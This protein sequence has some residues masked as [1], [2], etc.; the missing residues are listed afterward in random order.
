MMQQALRK[1]AVSGELADLFGERL[2][3]LGRPPQGDLRVTISWNTDATD[4]DLWV[5]EPDGVKCFY[6]NKWTKSGGELSEDMRQGYGPERYQAKKALTGEYRILVHYFA[7]NPNLLGGETH[8][9]VVV[10]RFAGTP[11]EETERYTVILK[12]QGEQAEVCRVR[13]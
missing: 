11:Q 8:V 5:I 9:N 4:V 2:E 7:G 12:K 13:F 10:T 3:R 1:K 6:G